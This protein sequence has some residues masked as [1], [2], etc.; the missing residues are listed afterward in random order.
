MPYL[1]IF[2]KKK[3]NDPY[4]VVKPLI[5][6]SI[7]LFILLTTGY[8]QVF[9]QLYR[10]DFSYS[11]I[12]HMK[13]M[14]HFQAPVQATKKDIYIEEEENRRISLKEH[15]RNIIYASFFYAHLQE[16]FF[17]PLRSY[18]SLRKYFSCASFFRSPN[19]TWCVLRL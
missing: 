11:A 7:I 5:K 8:T 12:K 19:P 9:T 3:A 18:S 1:S 6:Y 16:Y 14:E 17:L 4:L 15:S 2:C 13:G 10:I